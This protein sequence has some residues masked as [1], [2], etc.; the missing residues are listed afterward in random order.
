MSSYAEMKY[1]IKNGEKV[2]KPFFSSYEAIWM[3]FLNRL[4]FTL[5]SKWGNLPL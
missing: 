4:F 5:V 1:G 2:T 3:F